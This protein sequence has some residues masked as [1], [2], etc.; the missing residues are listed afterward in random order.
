[1]VNQNNTYLQLSAKLSTDVKLIPRV[2]EFMTSNGIIR[3]NFHEYI[4]K[5]LVKILS[6]SKPKK[7]LNIMMYGQP[8]MGK[9]TELRH[10]T[11]LL[12]KNTKFQDLFL[13]LYSELQRAGTNDSEDE[14]M[15]SNIRSGAIT[16]IKDDYTLKDFVKEAEDAG[17][18]P[19]IILDTLD[20]LLI[21][22]VIGKSNTM[23]KWSTFLEQTTRLGI[24]LFWTCRP[25]EWNFFQ[26]ELH[27]I[28]L[29]RTLQIELP[30]LQNW[31]CRPFPSSGSDNIEKWQEWTRHLQSQMPLFAGRWS[32]SYDKNHEL[33]P[34]FF[35]QL[36]QHIYGVWNAP[37]NGFDLTKLQYPSTIFYH[38]L[39]E[40]IHTSS[41]AENSLERS[42]SNILQQHFE[43]FV[44]QNTH[45]TRTHRLRFKNQEILQTLETSIST[46]TDMFVSQFVQERTL[47]QGK[48]GPFALRYS[49]QLTE[50]VQQFLNNNEQTQSNEF[51]EELSHFLLEFNTFKDEQDNIANQT[52]LFFDLCVSTGLIST[53]STTNTFEFTHQLLFEETLAT[54]NDLSIES[55]YFPSL[56]LRFLKPG[57]GKDL[58]RRE[59]EKAQIHWTGAAISFHPDIGTVENVDWNLWIEEAYKLGLIS[60]LSENE[61][62]EKSI[63]M[64]D[65]FE[66]KSNSALFLRGAPGTGKTYFCLNFIMEHLKRTSKKLLWR[67][68]TLNRPLVDSVR[69]QWEERASLPQNAGL[70]G[71]EK[72]NSGPLTVKEIILSVLKESDDIRNHNKKLL[73]FLQFKEGMMN[74]FS[75][76]NVNPPSFTDAWSDFTT[77][78]HHTS[79]SKSDVM[80]NLYDYEQ[81]Q[82]R[83]VS[84][85]QK[86]IALFAEYCLYILNETEY[87][88]YAHASYLARTQ[89][90]RN[91]GESKHKYDM[92]MIDEVQ[93][94][95]PSTMALMLLLLRPKFDSKAILVAGDDLQTVNRSGFQWFNF[96]QT[97]LKIL[98][99]T[100]SRAHLELNRLLDF[101]ISQNVDADLVTLKQVYRNA[102]KIAKLNDVFRNT[103]AHQYPS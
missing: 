47:E 21:D 5:T 16:Q 15:W 54:Q 4:G 32:G 77:L 8:S 103:F 75:R 20:I 100:D 24:A 93:D 14:S 67:Y 95:D 92:L 99:N 44:I 60:N 52:R 39:W 19:L 3:Q 72:P 10:L 97:T 34:Y 90:S 58:I 13:P 96:C 29:K 33:T 49:N 42:K 1:M 71:M 28:L 46:S 69:V 41:Y 6:Q 53:N 50:A 48:T 66:S 76:R 55:Y 31:E 61:M 79:G 88:T 56:A 87:V 62:N 45:I 86:Q 36:E 35:E 80:I 17:K 11:S 68:V 82:Y 65:Y 81:S 2:E 73:D 63:I 59:A 26:N 23:K 85:N 27:P 30:K 102:P 83:S 51:K 89:L 12:C 43:T 40:S 101:G 78:F 22:E 74:L 84:G 25:Y 38:A 37:L 57:G 94:I 18:T 64:D 7:A 9:T 91:R 98:S 70:A